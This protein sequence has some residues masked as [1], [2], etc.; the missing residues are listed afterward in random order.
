MRL[1]CCHQLE[2]IDVGVKKAFV[3]F[4]QLFLIG[5]A[6]V[7]ITA[8]PL[9]HTHLPGVFEQRI[10]VPHTVFSPD[11]PGEFS[12]FGHQM[13][14]DEFQ[15]SVLASNSP[16]LGF[17]ASPGDRKKPRIQPIDAGSLFF[18][19]P[20][21]S[22]SVSQELPLVDSNSRRSPHAHWYRGPPAS[23]SL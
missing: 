23:L 18:L 1:S 2:K 8:L 22:V 12:A 5:W 7:W 20:G 13:A 21:P 16:E 9:F 10:G 19:S 6:S 4:S 15:L 17:V 11:L 14:P 3:V